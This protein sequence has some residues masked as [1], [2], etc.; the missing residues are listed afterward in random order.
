V[1]QGLPFDSP[2]SLE[3]NLARQDFIRNF[4]SQIQ[5]QAELRAALDVGCGVGYLSKFLHDLG[6]EVVAMDGREDNILEARKRYPDITFLTA[7]AEKLSNEV[8]P[9][10]LVLCAGLLYHLEN[11]FR[12]IRNL[13][14]LT[15]KVLFIEGMCVPGPEPTMELLDESMLQDQGLNFVAFYPSEACLIKMLYR[16]GIPFV[17]IFLRLPGHP[18]YL[19]SIRRKRERTMMVASRLPLA[20]PN[21]VLAQEPVRPAAGLSDPWT[22][23]LMRKR[24]VVGELLRSLLRALRISSQSQ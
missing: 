1:K 2:L 16:S 18:L 14:A 20:A 10:D 7:D 4:L 9:R 23:G 21:L 8:E 24:Y 13:H 12:V 19:H 5:M 22:T 15:S 3:F 11:P 17:Y 6:F